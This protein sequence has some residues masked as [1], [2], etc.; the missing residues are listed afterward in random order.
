MSV[1]TE[2]AIQIEGCHSAQTLFIVHGRLVLRLAQ[3]FLFV[4]QNI[5]PAKAKLRFAALDPIVG[6]M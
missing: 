6:K 5:S 3:A 2:D 1:R 4:Y